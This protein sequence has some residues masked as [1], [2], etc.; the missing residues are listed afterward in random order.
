MAKKIKKALV[1]L[2]GP[3]PA[4]RV[5]FIPP[6]ELIPIDLIDL[7]F[8]DDAGMANP[9]EMSGTKLALLTEGIKE[10]GFLQSVLVRRKPNGRF[11]LLD[12]HHRIEAARVAGFTEVSACVLPE[13][14][15]WRAIGHALGLNRLRGD[16]NVTV[17]AELMQM[18]QLEADL[19][20]DQISV[21]T[22]FSESE[23]AAL[24]DASTADDG[25]IID[26]AAGAHVDDDEKSLPRPFMLE[27]TFETS[28]VRTKVK[29]ALKK[30]SGASKDLSVGLINVLGLTDEED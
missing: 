25:D 3:V 24:L 15:D 9:N 16:M 12:G 11:G 4:P 20:A 13:T 28:A 1:P 23:V 27:L 10:Y 8:G 6:T 7:F 14:E 5:M 29:R 17:A 21:L 30:A 26:D 2:P 19:S 18:M 22:G